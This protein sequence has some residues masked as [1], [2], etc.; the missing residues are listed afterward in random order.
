[1]VDPGRSRYC[2][3][4]EILFT[5]KKEHVRGRACSGIIVYVISNTFEYS[6]EIYKSTNILSVRV[7]TAKANIIVITVYIPPGEK[8]E[9][10]F[11]ELDEHLSSTAQTYSE[12]GILLC[13]G[14]NARI[15]QQVESNADSISFLGKLTRERHSRDQKKNTR[16]A[17]LVEIIDKNDM[18]ILNGR[19][20]SDSAGEFTFVG[21]QGKK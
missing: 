10:I 13:G 11:I 5:G 7:R 18:H 12:D 1:M 4:H 21:S 6:E 2:W 9:Q 14:F 20:P 8:H 19:L 3:L 16:G 15:G 17:T